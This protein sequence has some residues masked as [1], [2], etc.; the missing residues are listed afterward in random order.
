MYKLIQRTQ[1]DFF[2][3]ISP[4]NSGKRDGR[5]SAVLTPNSGNAT[6][7]WRSLNGLFGEINRNSGMTIA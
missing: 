3:G 1:A 6:P 7:R 5:S 4:L 2:R